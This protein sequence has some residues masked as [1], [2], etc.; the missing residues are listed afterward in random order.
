VW[1][2]RGERESQ[3]ME[4]ER[5]KVRDTEVREIWSGIG[6]RG[7]GGRKGLGMKETCFKSMLMEIL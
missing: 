4:R 2:F 1:P 6:N 3:D 7:D 5:M